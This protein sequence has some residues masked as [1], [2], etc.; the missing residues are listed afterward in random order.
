MGSVSV[1]IVEELGNN[2]YILKCARCNETGRMSRDGDGRAPWLVCPACHGVGAQP[3]RG[4]IKIL[5]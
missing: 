1:I 4:G 5:R 2:K 3:I